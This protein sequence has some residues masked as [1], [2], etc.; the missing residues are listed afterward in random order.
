MYQQVGFEIV[1]TKDMA[2]V[3]P[4]RGDLPWSVALADSWRR[5]VSL[6]GGWGRVWFMSK[7]LRCSL[8]PA[9]SAC[10]RAVHVVG[11]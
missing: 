9:T 1:E 10:R 5:A 7:H 2:V 8:V 3:K 6:A 11:M 4:A